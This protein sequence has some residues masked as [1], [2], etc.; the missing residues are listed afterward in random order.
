MQIIS[1]SCAASR[2]NSWKHWRRWRTPPRTRNSAG[3]YRAQMQTARQLERLE[4]VIRASPVDVPTETCEAMQGLIA[5]GRKIVTAEEPGEVKD[6]A[7]IA[8]AQRIEL[9]EIAVYGTA[10][11]LAD[12]LD[13]RTARELL[14]E[15]LEEEGRGQRLAH[16]AGHRRAHRRGSQRAR[17]HLTH[18][19]MRK[20]NS[21]VW[22][23]ERACGRRRG[24]ECHRGW[25]APSTDS[26]LARS[27]ARGHHDSLD[28]AIKPSA[29]HIDQPALDGL[30]FGLVVAEL[31]NRIARHRRIMGRS[32]APPR[33]TLPRDRNQHG[34]NP[35]RLSRRR[36]LR[37]THQLPKGTAESSASHELYPAGV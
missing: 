17:S 5:D 23:Y 34:G 21:S 7:L 28:F 15:T 3:V 22:L 30:R 33:T 24:G 35:P 16:Q 2:H 31:R 10:R 13:Q 32:L 19:A 29:H 6:V 26:E 1:V 8:A 27:R 12:Q 20:R 36:R 25:H 37:A 4:E 18:L 9:Y 11:A 14:T